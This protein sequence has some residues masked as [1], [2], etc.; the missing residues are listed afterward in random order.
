V[1][2]ETC[3]GGS[4]LRKLRRRYRRLTAG[5]VADRDERFDAVLRAANRAIDRSRVL[6]DQRYEV[7]AVALLKYTNVLM[8]GA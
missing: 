2:E 3:L 1:G 8:D 7:A 6:F 4:C 5:E